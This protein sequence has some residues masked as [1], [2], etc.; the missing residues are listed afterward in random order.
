MTPTTFVGVD[1]NRVL[2]IHKPGV[3][4]FIWSSHWNNFRM[5]FTEIKEGNYATAL[6]AE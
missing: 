4:P 3:Q 5:K 2:G 6:M 1:F